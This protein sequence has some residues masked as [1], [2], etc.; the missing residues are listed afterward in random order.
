MTIGVALDAGRR[1]L[2]EVSETAGLDAQ[3]LLAKVSGVGR[4]WLLAHPDAALAP[5]QVREFQRALERCKAGEALPY[6][7]G[8]WE[9]H[10]RAYHITRDVLIPRPETELLVENA[11]EFLRRR[12]EIRLAAD[13]GTGCGCIAVTLLDMIPG[14]VFLAGDLSR[15]VL[16]VARSNAARHNVAARFHAVRMDLLDGVTP[17]LPLICAN[18]PYIPTAELAGLQVGQREPRLALDGGPDGL[19]SL[20]RFLVDLPRCLAPDGRAFL[21]IGA[22]QAEAILSCL[23]TARPRLRGWVLPDFAGHDRLVVIERDAE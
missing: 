3:V 22:G 23:P 1:A 16:R 19:V 4:P 17:P 2:A 11:A 21:E 20:R 12:P 7:L 9:F 13:V 18:L 5:E 10:G 15:G 14:L 8:E 6:V